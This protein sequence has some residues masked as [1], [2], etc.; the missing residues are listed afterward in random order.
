M[1]RVLVVEDDASIRETLRFILEDGGHEVQE[2]EDGV[3]ALAALRATRTPMV[4][5]LDVLM[6]R[7]GG[8]EVLRAVAEDSR[9]AERH[10]YILV[11]ATSETFPLEFAN[12]LTRMQVPVI[13]KP[14]DIDRL[15]GGVG[16]AA[17]RLS[18]GM[19]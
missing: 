7:M 2:A 11:T 14:F 15:L 13:A 10:A 3:E 9:L 8:R 1:A 16:A 4:V 18:A 17:Q 19:R 5:L 12:L 6:P